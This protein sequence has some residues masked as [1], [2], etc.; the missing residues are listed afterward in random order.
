MANACRSP[1]YPFGKQGWVMP[2]ANTAKNDL[3]DP[4]VPYARYD[5]MNVSGVR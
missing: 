5:I 3:L 1:E 2:W 4:R